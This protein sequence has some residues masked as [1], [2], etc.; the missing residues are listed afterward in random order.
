MLD[1]LHRLG[2]RE[3]GYRFEQLCAWLL[4]SEPAF[5][6]RRAYRWNEWR[7]R[8]LTRDG[9]D[10]G[11]DT[12]IDIVAETDDGG[13]W[14]VQCKCYAE[15][16]RTQ[17]ASAINPGVRCAPRR[18]NVRGCARRTSPTNGLGCRAHRRVRDQRGTSHGRLA[19]GRAGPTFFFRDARCPVLCVSC[20][21]HCLRSS[22][23]TRRNIVIYG[24]FLTSCKA[25]G[26]L[27]YFA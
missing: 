20:T 18:W 27:A 14:A 1:Q 19:I 5:P 16:S 26:E 17:A 8:R 22:A 3:K 25:D 21:Q 12:G 24:H 13:L 15:T 11:L 2:D 23:D 7:E 9:V 10:V 6:V 4:Q